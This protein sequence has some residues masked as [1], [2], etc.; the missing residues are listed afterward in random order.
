MQYPFPDNSAP[1]VTGACF[2]EPFDSP[3][4]NHSMKIKPHRPRSCLGWFV[5]VF[6]VLLLIFVSG[7][8]Y[9]Q[10]RM[11]QVTRDLASLARELGY[12]PDT[13]LHY[14]IT[15]RDVSIITGSAY[16][17]AKLYYATPMDLV[18]FT[19]RLNQLEPETKEIRLQN[20]IFDLSGLIPGL[21]VYATD[22]LPTTPASQR[23]PPMMYRWIVH[24]RSH[25]TNV[26][27]YDTTNLNV[28]MQYGGRRVEG[29]I[30]QIYTEGGA[31]P[32]WMNCRTTSSDTS[33]PPFD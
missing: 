28:Q 25:K 4:G 26:V 11:A 5:W 13:Y 1:D 16:C 32:I 3:K 12:T 2:T 23:E 14:E 27:F 9:A 19:E 7:N 29:N 15:V 22:F 30:A 20:M 33:A 21:K 31:F 24:D 6:G 18:E 17:V 10:V 8:V